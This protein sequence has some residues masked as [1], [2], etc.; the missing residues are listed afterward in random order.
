MNDFTN[1]YSRLCASPIRAENFIKTGE[2]GTRIFNVLNTNIKTLETVGE[3]IDTVYS[4]TA[5]DMDH[6][7]KIKRLKDFNFRSID[8]HDDPRA[9]TRSDVIKKAGKKFGGY[10]SAFVTL[11]LYLLLL[12]TG[13]GTL[14][15]AGI[16]TRDFINDIP[17]F[18]KRE[19]Y[20]FA[21][22]IA[23]SGPFLNDNIYQEL[24]VYYGDNKVYKQFID[25]V[26]DNYP[27]T[28]VICEVFLREFSN[29]D[30]PISK[31][32]ANFQKSSLKKDALYAII[33]YSLDQFV[34]I[35]K[36]NGLRTGKTTKD[37]DVF[38]SE[39]FDFFNDIFD[40]QLS[41]LGNLRTG[42]SVESLKSFIEVDL[43]PA[44]REELQQCICNAF[45]LIVPAEE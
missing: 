4:L 32:L 39:Y 45:N 6:K 12:D 17:I 27:N 41:W 36:M 38:L 21:K 43:L 40:G 29:A 3:Y 31:R 24:V 26:K 15:T 18:L 5:Y 44:E 16:R 10:N 14:S 23:V 8:N 13:A 11:L 19:L 37:S 22:Q 33:F 7:Q 25:F 35:N 30:S 28:G 2:G 9:T 1:E 42:D 20:V 34:R